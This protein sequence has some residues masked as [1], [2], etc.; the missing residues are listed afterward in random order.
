MSDGRGILARGP[1]GSG[2]IEARWREDPFELPAEVERQADAAVDGLRERGSPAH[3]G[4]ATRLAGWRE[5]D[6]R[7]CSTSSRCAGPCAC[8][9]TRATA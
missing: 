4:V 5:E 6:G 7:L 1:W 2:Q 9:R 8:S 3:D